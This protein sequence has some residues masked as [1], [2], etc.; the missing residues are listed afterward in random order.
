MKNKKTYFPFGNDIILFGTLSIV[1]LGVLLYIIIF[2]PDLVRIIIASILFSFLFY[3]ALKPLI[4]YR[5]TMTDSNIS[6]NK[7]YGL[8]KEDR[9][10]E[11][12]NINLNDIK[13]FKVIYSNSTSNGTKINNLNKKFKYIEFILNDA[14]TKRIS[15]TSMNNKQ[16][17]KI[18]NKIEELTKIE[19]TTK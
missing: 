19:V 11:K 8:F 14:A 15:V 7:D 1:A 16:I 6:I 9:I 5:I 13:E 12:E 4:V 17:L 18:V 2:S 10:Q 3:S